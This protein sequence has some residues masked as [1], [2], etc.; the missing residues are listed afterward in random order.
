MIKLK[1]ARSLLL[2]GILFICISFVLTNCGTD[3]QLKVSDPNVGQCALDLSDVPGG[4]IVEVVGGNARFPSIAG[5]NLTVEAWMKPGAADPNSASGV[6]G[7]YD[8][9][10]ALMWVKNNIPKFAIRVEA[11]PTSTDFTVSG[12]QLPSGD[13]AHIAGMLTNETHTHAAS[14]S[15]TAGVLAES[16]H[17]DIFINGS[18]VDCATSGSNGVSDP[19][20][21]GDPKEGNTAHIGVL[22]STITPLV[23]G[24]ISTTNSNFMGAIDEVR[25]WTVARSADEIDECK[26]SE[27]T[28]SGD[29]ALNSDILKG[30]WKMNECKGGEVFDWS[31]GG[32]AMGIETSDGE[33]LEDGWVA[34]VF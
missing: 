8:G 4:Q 15:C 6:F 22:P 18:F 29:C 2:S 9:A 24:N 25:L 10:G 19:L 3:P 30:Y 13:W 17:L 34:G 33:F 23:D 27:L 21:A 20:K 14:A 5:D 1:S 32:T 31:G 7:R 26:D 12:T 28:S 11:L 16:H